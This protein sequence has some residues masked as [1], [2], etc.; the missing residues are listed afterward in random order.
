[1]PSLGNRVLRLQRTG[2]GESADRE[3]LRPR[4]H[5]SHGIAETVERCHVRVRPVMSPP[6]LPLQRAR[7][8]LRRHR[9]P[10]A[11]ASD[12]ESSGVVRF[13]E[14]ASRS[15]RVAAPRPGT[16]LPPAAHR[17]RSY[18]VR[19]RFRRLRLLRAVDPRTQRLTSLLALG[20]PGVG[21]RGSDSVAVG[22]VRRLAARQPRIR[23]ARTREQCG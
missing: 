21:T 22:A 18:P 15:P 5:Q 9:T 14:S 16:R 8:M 19:P 12:L 11:T 10:P 17:A 1:M 13:P 23:P 3:L 7:Q 20:Y 4:G 2:A 6:V